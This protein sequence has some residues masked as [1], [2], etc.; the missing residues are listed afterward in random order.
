M[1]RL[2]SSM[3]EGVH[4]CWHV[5]LL[6]SLRSSLLS[7]LLSKGVLVLLHVLQVLQVLQVLHLLQVLH[8][9][10]EKHEGVL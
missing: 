6:S 10:P 5:L 2:L 9:F 1:A 3:Q 4:L 7:S 8:V